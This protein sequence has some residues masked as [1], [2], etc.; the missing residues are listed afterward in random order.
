MI[1]SMLIIQQKYDID[2]VILI[3]KFYR[4]F[5]IKRYILIPSSF[6]Q[7]KKWRKNQSWYHGGRKYECEKYQIKKVEIIIKTKLNKT[8]DRIN[9]V[10]NDIENIRHPYKNSNGYDYTENFD[11]KLVRNNN[12]YYFNLKFVCETG[13]A[14][15]TK[16]KD[17]YHFIENQIKY[18][19]KHK[20]SNIYFINILD[21]YMSYHNM[22]KFKYLI[23]KYDIN[24]NISNYLF[25]GD[26]S[27]FQKSSKFS[28][29]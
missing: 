18:L 28:N 25:V 1:D 13:G 27:Q 11:R 24:N 19:L 8:D 2:K 15:T 6:Y 9:E 22:D 10:K 20:P 7:T 12:I 5:L 21:G 14:Q 29:I 4:R 3:Q 16:L 23:N 26:L 17:V